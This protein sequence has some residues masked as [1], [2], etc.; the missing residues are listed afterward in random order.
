[1]TPES[2]KL[3]IKSELG[4]GIVYLKTTKLMIDGLSS[5]VSANSYNFLNDFSLP[6]DTIEEVDEAKYSRFFGTGGSIFISVAEK[7]AISE[8]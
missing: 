1:M 8:R 7:V 6:D 3:G 5:R 4:G 2:S